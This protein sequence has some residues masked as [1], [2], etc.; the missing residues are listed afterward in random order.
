M[1]PTRSIIPRPHQ[2]H[3]PRRNAGGRRTDTA[4]NRTTNLKPGR[5]RAGRRPAGSPRTRRGPVRGPRRGPP[6]PAG[7]QQTAAWLPV[8]VPDQIKENQPKP[9]AKTTAVDPI[10]HARLQTHSLPTSHESTTRHLRPSRL[11]THDTHVHKSKPAPF[12]PCLDVV[13]FTSIYI[14]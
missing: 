7:T 11:T 8:A 2:I 14:C 10:S 5:P 1:T 12:R 9:R 4:S 6:A 13:V 3:S